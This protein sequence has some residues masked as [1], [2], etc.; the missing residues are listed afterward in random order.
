MNAARLA[1]WIIESHAPAI[2]NLQIH[3]YIW[4]PDRKGV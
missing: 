1:R 2:L 3:K 4:G